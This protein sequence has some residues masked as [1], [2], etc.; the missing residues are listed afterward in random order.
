MS[1]TREIK[2]VALIGL[3]AIGSYLSSRLQTVLGD[4]LRVIAGGERRARL[5]RDGVVIN[6]RPYHFH[7]VSPEEETGCVDLAIIITKMTGLSQA[8]E[9]IKKQIGPDTI[10]MSPLNGIE[11]EEQVAAV[12]GWDRI[13]YSLVRLSVVMDGNQVSFNPD[14]AC[15]EF[16]ERRNE[17]LSGKVLAVKDLFERAG[18]RPIVQEDME[19]A[20]WMKYVCNVSENQVAAVLGIPFGAWGMSEHANALRVMVAKEVIDIA[21]AKGIMIDEDYAVKHL[22]HLKRVPFG[23]KPSTLQ[24]IEHGRKTEVEMF[25]G[26]MIRMG[27]EVGVP[28]PYNE[29]LY[30]AI[31]VLEEKNAG[32]F[33]GG[34]CH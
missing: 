31:K 13:L 7:I 34:E 11:S 8:L 2:S 9:D 21:R 12:Y 24:D 26:T 14:T 19:K 29:L 4:D 28:T 33:A 20:I 15:V 30:H 25:G 3:G 10:L 18:I 22:E 16:G 17:A 1:G 5:E 32:A 27:K 6:G 23:N